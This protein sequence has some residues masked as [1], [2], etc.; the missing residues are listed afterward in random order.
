MDAQADQDSL[1]HV[2]AG[3]NAILLVL[4]RCSKCFSD[5]L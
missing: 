4:S 2:L 5:D 1:E 3:T